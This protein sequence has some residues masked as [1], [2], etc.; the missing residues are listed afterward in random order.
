MLK[1]VVM[2]KLKDHALGMDKP[3]LAAELKRRLEA[4]PGSV[5]GIL[6]LEVGL[7]V[8]QA[9]TASDVVLVS[10]FRDL[11]GLKAYAEH[12]AHLEVVAFVRQ[13]AE[14]RRACDYEA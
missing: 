6:S 4:L 10:A 13:V 1:H 14:E 8:V 5:P 7:N 2:W 11:A 9:D 12:P 3:A